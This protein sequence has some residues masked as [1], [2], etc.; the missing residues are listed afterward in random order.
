M[1]RTRKGKTMKGNNLLF[2]STYVRFYFRQLTHIS[3]PKAKHRWR[4][5]RSDNFERANVR[6]FAGE[7]VTKPHTEMTEH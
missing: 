1:L 3:K 6:T 7:K 5:L 4:D 2:L